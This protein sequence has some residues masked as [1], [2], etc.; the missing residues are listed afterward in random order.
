MPGTA[1]ARLTISFGR[2]VTACRGGS[3]KQNGIASIRKPVID[4][5]AT[6][7]PAIECVR[8]D[9]LYFGYN[10]ITIRGGIAGAILMKAF[11]IISIILIVLGVS[12]MAPSL[13][14][15]GEAEDYALDDMHNHDGSHPAGS[16]DCGSNYMLPGETARLGSHSFMI[17]GQDD[18]THILAEHRSGTPPHN[19]QFLLRIRLDPDEMEA[20]RTVLKGSMTLPAFTTIYYDEQGVQ[21]DRTF[22]CLQDLPEIFG[23]RQINKDKF[24]PLFPIRASLQKNASHEGD[25]RIKATVVAGLFFTLD[26]ED[27]EVI[28]YRYLPAYLSQNSLRK[29]IRENPQSEMPLLGHAPLFAAESAQTASQHRSYIASDGAIALPGDACQHDYYLKNTAVPKTIHNFMLVAEGPGNTVTAVYYAD[30]APHNWQSV[31][32]LKLADKEMEIYR[33]AKSNSKIPPVLQ[34]RVGDKNYFFCMGDLRKQIAS[35]EFAVSGTVYRDSNLGDYRLGTAVGQIDLDSSKISVLVNRNL[36]SFL[37][38]LA[39]ARD[40]LGRSN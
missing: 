4:K 24:S 26:R 1:S 3:A 19:Y 9:K 14:G 25:F 11:R 12:Q 31:L 33:A 35:R 16:T 20:Y 21:R 22:F 5:T 32:T 15:A 2:S 18:A 10:V 23:P 17:L 34:T 8:I 40:V 27:I 36:A 7:N 13:S 29:A 6:E 37:N 38:P 28:V 39:V 30:Q